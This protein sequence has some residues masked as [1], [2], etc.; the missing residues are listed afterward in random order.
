MYLFSWNL[1]KTWEYVTHA[2]T[3]LSRRNGEDHV[4]ATFQ[5]WP[6]KWPRAQEALKGFPL[7][8]VNVPGKVVVLHSKSLKLVLA[9]QH[10]SE[11]AV[12]ARFRTPEVRS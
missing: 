12:V 8:V 5:E 7:D 3:H 11:R 4:I 9:D 1:H 6:K 10:P 2:L